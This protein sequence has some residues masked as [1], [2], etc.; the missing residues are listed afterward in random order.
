MAYIP[1]EILNIIFSYVERPSTNKLLK[2]VID[3]CYEN[4]YDPYYIET[5]YCNYCNDY[6]FSQWYFMYRRLWVINSQYNTTNKNKK[7]YKHTPRIIPVGVD[8][9]SRIKRLKG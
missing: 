4:D 8:K 1:L 5:W 9:I 2:Y 7:C 3:E 6:S